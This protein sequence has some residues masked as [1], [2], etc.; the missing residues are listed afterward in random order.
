[1]RLGQNVALHNY[2]RHSDELSGK[3]LLFQWVPDRKNTRDFPD[4]RVLMGLALHRI[5]TY[6]LPTSHDKAEPLII[7]SLIEIELIKASDE[8]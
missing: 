2:R 4:C 7:D 5:N 6:W 1:M 3:S 8:T